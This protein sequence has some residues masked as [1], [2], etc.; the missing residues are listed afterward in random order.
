MKNFN[1]NLQKNFP[2][3]VVSPIGNGSYKCFKSGFMVQLS[4]EDEEK[5]SWLNRE[6]LGV[7]FTSERKMIN[8]ILYIL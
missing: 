4:K 5:Q 6:L 7:T 3:L 8:T 1:K 2:N